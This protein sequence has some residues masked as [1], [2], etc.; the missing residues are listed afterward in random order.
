MVSDYAANSLSNAIVLMQITAERKALLAKYNLRRDRVAQ[1]ESEKTQHKISR[2]NIK[3]FRGNLFRN[4]HEYLQLSRTISSLENT[5]KNVLR[6]LAHT[7]RKTRMKNGASI[8]AAT[9]PIT[10]T[11]FGAKK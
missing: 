7:E 2:N 8:T 11:G 10:G 6:K 1:L 4:V 9:A 5:H 3:F